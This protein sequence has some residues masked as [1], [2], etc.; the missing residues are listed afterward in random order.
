M[1]KATQNLALAALPFIREVDP[2]WNDVNEQNFEPTIYPA[3]RDYFASIKA[4][5]E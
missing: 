3:H 5:L 2:R 4:A 1:P